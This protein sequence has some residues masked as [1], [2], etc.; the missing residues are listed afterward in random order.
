MFPDLSSNP[1]WQRFKSRLR[2]RKSLKD[3]LTHLLTLT[4]ISTAPKTRHY[5]H[6]PPAGPSQITATKQLQGDI[7]L[8]AISGIQNEIIRNLTD[9]GGDVTVTI[10]VSASK[11]GGFSQHTLRAVR[12]NGDALQLELQIDESGS[13]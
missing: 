12:E 11:A 6:H 10:T 5:Q 8:D 4:P 13:G 9:D 3:P 2:S 7:S 1:K